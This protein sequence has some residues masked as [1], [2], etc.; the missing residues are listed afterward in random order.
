MA[1]VPTYACALQDFEGGIEAPLTGY[2]AHLAWS[3]LQKTTGQVCVDVRKA[4]WP[5]LLVSGFDGVLPEGFWVLRVWG[6]TQIAGLPPSS[7]SGGYM[8]GSEC[9]ANDDHL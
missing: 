5:V 7:V 4:S 2:V 8:L 6:V 3:E 1:G 9:A